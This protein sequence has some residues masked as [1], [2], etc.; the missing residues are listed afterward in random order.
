MT[1]PE[2]IVRDELIGLSAR[3][4]EAT[5]KDLVGCAGRVIRETT[6]T[7]VIRPDSDSTHPLGDPEAESSQIPKHGTT[8][9]FTLPDGTRVSVDGDRLIARPARRTQTTEVSPWV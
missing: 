4:V 8:F 7:I 1:T 9:V 5:N 3:V 6:N 2:T